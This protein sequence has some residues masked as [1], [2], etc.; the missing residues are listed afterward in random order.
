L[1]CS[2]AA[3]RIGVADFS[4]ATLS[5]T[6]CRMALPSVSPLCCDAVFT[7]GAIALTSDGIC[8]GS[9]LSSL[10]DLMAASTAPQLS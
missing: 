3:L 1:F 2:T 8:P 10:S 4:L 5:T 6:F 9:G 7:E